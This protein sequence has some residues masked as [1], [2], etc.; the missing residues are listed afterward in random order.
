LEAGTGAVIARVAV[1]REPFAAALTPD[2][3]K[4]YVCNLLPTGPAN[5]EQSAASISVIDTD[6]AKVVATIEMP[7]GTT[8]LRGI[9]MSPD[10]SHAYAVHILARYQMPT[11][12]LERGWM[13]TN[14]LSIVNVVDDKLLNTVLL[15]DVELGAANPWAVACTA[16]G[17]CIAVTHAGTHEVSL[18]D[19]DALHGR[20]NT[21][22]QGQRVTEVT[23][24]AADVPNDLSFL[25]GIRRRVPIAG[26]GPRAIALAG[27]KVF[28]AEYFSDSV[29]AFD[30]A[31]A[32]PAVTALKLG[33]DVAPTA[34]RRGE[35]LFSDA[36]MC[37]QQWQSCISCHPDAR[38]DAINWDLLN[39][40]IGNSK[41]TKSMLLSHQ[42]PPVMSLGVR[43]NAEIAVRAGMKFIQFVLRPE[44]DAAA[45]DAYLKS[46]K[47]VPSPHLVDG[48]LSNSAERGKDVFERAGCASC[49]S[50][51][52]Y[53]NLKKFNLDTGTEQDAGKP[54]DTP[55]LIEAWRTAPYLH[56]GRAA[57]M[58]ELL[59]KYNPGD[60]HG[61]TSG[62]SEQ[63]L[64]DLVEFLLSL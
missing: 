26:N 50:G 45:L 22:A 36:M 5:D 15:D 62:L 17:K 3:K 1:P 51:A 28:A 46:M 10:G 18:I 4:L 30:A 19:R 60:K 55:S 44:E 7:N 61:N 31:E 37:F 25:P 59:T 41:N 29:S 12:Q 33:P 54:F 20:L 34:E 16:D 63:E 53:T 47:P 49:H 48:K 6:A 9:C 52:L 39:D 43:D 57:D 40:G 13:N 35:M 11:T 14:A 64:K 21:A 32:K 42:T 8:G 23:S 38:A 58:M 24:S 2:G 56:D 27:S